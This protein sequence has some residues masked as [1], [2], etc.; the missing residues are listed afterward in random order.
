MIHRSGLRLVGIDWDEVEAEPPAS[1]SFEQYAASWN[2]RLPTQPV[3]PIRMALAALE[4]ASRRMEDLA[5]EFGCC[6]S[7]NTDDTDRPRA[8]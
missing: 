2:S 6:D 3:D 1:Y 8:A 7:A 5:R 4:H